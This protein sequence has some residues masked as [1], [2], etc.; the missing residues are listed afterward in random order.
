MDTVTS[1]RAIVIGASSGIGLAIVQQLL[2][3]GWHVRSCARRPAPITHERLQHHQV[4]VASDD[5]VPALR[6][7][8][9]DDDHLP[10]VV[11]HCAGVGEAFDPARMAHEVE[12]LRVN[13]VSVAATLEVV[14]PRFVAAR[15]GHF[16]GLSSLADAIISPEAPAYSA[17][18]AGM[19]NYLAGVGLAVRRFGV[20]ITN[21]RFGFVDTR[22]AKSPVKPFMVDADR[23]ARVVL[24]TLRTR[25]LRVSY[26]QRT[27]WLVALLGRIRSLQVGFAR[28]SRGV[29]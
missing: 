15:G 12:A 14:L 2:D 13:L 18:K 7:W 10:D 5:F 9:D 23:A 20:A 27:A 19:S 21:V 8:L 22:M 6:S 4:D 3:A 28:A 26:P 25:W 1:S 16:I 29:D 24:R 17:S 11:I